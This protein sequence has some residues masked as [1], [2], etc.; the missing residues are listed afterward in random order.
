MFVHLG[1]DK[2]LTVNGVS[3][4]LIVGLCTVI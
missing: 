3:Y 1:K 2:N 4:I